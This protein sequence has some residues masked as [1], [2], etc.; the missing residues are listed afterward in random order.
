MQKNPPVTSESV[1]ESSPSPRKRL[2]FLLGFALAIAVIVGGTIYLVIGDL[3][4]RLNG[5]RSEGKAVLAG[6]TVQPF[7]T[8]A[9]NDAFPIS[10]VP[11]G[12]G[13]FYLS[14]LGPG[15]ISKASAQGVVSSWFSRGQIKAAGPMAM[16]KDGMLYIIEFATAG[17]NATGIIRRIDSEGKISTFGNVPNATG[18][19]LVILQMT[20]D[21]N[22]NLYF[23]DALSGQLWKVAPDG[24]MTPWW[25]AQD[26][27]VQSARLIGLAYDPVHNALIVGDRGTN[28][29]YRVSLDGDSP[30]SE[31][32]YREAG[33]DVQAITIDE[34]GNPIL[35]IW[36]GTEAHLSRLETSGSLT[37]LAEGFR[38]P[39]SLLYQDGKIYVVNS[40]VLGLFEAVKPKLPF[41]IDI[42][43]LNQVE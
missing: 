25:T 35:A 16:G 43:A 22:G 13:S 4:S 36:Q 26:Y 3:N 37:K 6:V 11:Q 42:V 29:L 18:A 41:T 23:T 19:A 27:G 20:F 38:T 17:E 39:T 31:L 14:E 12:D 5:N 28:S 32:L 10:L 8:L 24:T 1:P 30:N 40:D 33:L 9:E 2:L 34:E 21:G 7:A 15:T